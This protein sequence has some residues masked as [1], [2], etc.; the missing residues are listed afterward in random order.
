MPFTLRRS[1]VSR[2]FAWWSSHDP[3]SK[4]SAGII[5]EGIKERAVI[6]LSKPWIRAA[7]PNGRRVMQLEYAIV[8]VKVMQSSLKYFCTESASTRTFSPLSRNKQFCFQISHFILV[9]FLNSG[10]LNFDKNETREYQVKV[11]DSGKRKGLVRIYCVALRGGERTWSSSLFP[12]A[13]FEL[14]WGVEVGGSRSPH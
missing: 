14:T 2:T 13:Y 3:T 4:A 8:R 6:S 12:L 10:S 5:C 11:S 9:C 7:P 1:R